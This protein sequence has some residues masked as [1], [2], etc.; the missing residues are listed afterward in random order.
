[1]GE[2]HMLQVRAAVE[3]FESALPRLRLRHDGQF[4]VIRDGVF[5]PAFF[6][7]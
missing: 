6:S 7:S 1:M 2:D 5:E 4:A 3:A